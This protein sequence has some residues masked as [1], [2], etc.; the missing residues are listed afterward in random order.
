[1]ELDSARMLKASVRAQYVAPVV[2]RTDLVRAL[3]LPAQVEIASQWR[4]FSDG[5]DSGSLIFSSA[6]RRAVGL[7]FAGSP[8]GGLFGT[9]VTYACPIRA[10]LSATETEL[11]T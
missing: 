6:D 9:G 10:V 7:L 2:Q 3:G 8:T 1:M 11:V 4:P 5:G